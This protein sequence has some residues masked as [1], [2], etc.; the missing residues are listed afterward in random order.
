MV[1]CPQ[2]FSHL[3]LPPDYE[4]FTNIDFGDK[5]N[6]TEAKAI[7]KVLTLSSEIEGKKNIF[8]LQSPAKVFKEC[9]NCCC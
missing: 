3:I 7:D 6:I 8:I 5:S 1:T 9:K 2:C 4:I